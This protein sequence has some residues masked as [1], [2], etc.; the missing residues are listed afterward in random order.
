[1]Q[2]LAD[3]ASLHAWV[4]AEY[5]LTSSNKWVCFGGSYSGALS[6][7]F[8]L[9][10]PSLVVGA[11]ASSAPVHA[12]LDFVEYLQ[13]VTASLNTA[14]AGSQCTSRIAAATATIQ[15]QLQTQ[16]GRQQLASTFNLCAAPVSDLDVQN[17]VSSI[18]GAFMGIVQYNRDNFPGNTI[19]IDTVV[20]R[21]GDRACACLPAS[22]G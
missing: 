19:T 1:M 17:F 12:E 11:I 3:L 18:A 10:Y 6:A 22:T 7:W 14:Q 9:K 20:R 4:T 2:A 15:Q 5:N 8:R 16:S 21:C 13:V